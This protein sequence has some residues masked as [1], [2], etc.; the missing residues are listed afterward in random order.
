MNTT[1]AAQQAGVT[2]ATIRA[3][4]RRNVIAALKVTG[5]WVIDAA[6]LAHR[7]QIGRTHVADRYT[8]QTVD[9][10]HL[11]RVATFHRVVRTDGTEPGWRGDAR[12]IDHIYADRARA[13]AVA[14]FLNRTPDCYRLELRQAGR[15]FSSSGGWR[16]VVTG[17]RDGDPHR[18]SARID[19]GWQPPATSSSTTAIGH[20][21]GL[22]LTHDKGAEKRIA[23]HAEK[24]AIA[25]AEQE[26]RQAREA[27]LAELRRQ[28]GQL[29]TPRQVDYI[30]D[31]LEQRRISGE[32]GGFYLGPADRAAIE[33]MSKNEASVYI[34]SLKGEY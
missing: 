27:Q 3:W 10:E 28:K 16:W 11:G 1:A 32:G 14:E 6:S 7:I 17:G 24:Q 15:T 8:V 12:L 31:L 2:T 25:A 33:E 19:V 34:T 29:A 20:V 22:T 26:V 21:I 30:L 9:K 23:E 13:E 4:C 18:V 5:R